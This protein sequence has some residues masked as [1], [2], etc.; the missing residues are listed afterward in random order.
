MSTR[1]FA[2]NLFPPLD[3]FELT[4]R[5]RSRVDPTLLNDFEMA[6]E[7]DGDP[8]KAPV[9]EPIVDPV[10]ALKPNQKS[11]IPYASRL[12]DQKLRDK[13]NDQKHKFF[14]IFQ[15]LNF[16]I[17]F[18]YALILMPKFG[19]TIKSLLT[20][21]GKLFE[22]ARSPLNELARKAEGPR[23]EYSQEVLGFSDVIASGNPTPYYDLIVS[24]SS[25]TL[26]PFGDSDFLLEEVDAFLALKDDSTLP[27]VDHSYYD[28]KGDIL[29]LKAFFNDDPSLP[30]PNQGMYL[31]QVQKELK[32]CK[33]K[34]DKSLIHE[35]PEVELKDLPPHLE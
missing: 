15:D 19:L 1:S 32:F 2:R 5:R 30:P 14:K 11:S 28:S 35:P 16:N 26:T 4:T 33:A 25:P 6:T 20:N 31:P 18:T 21:K 23:Q 34:N 7:G 17:S 27:E 9:V 29:L 22:L 8:P 3:N 10:S 13:T 24:T 12:H